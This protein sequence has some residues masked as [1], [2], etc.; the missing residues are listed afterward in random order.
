MLIYFANEDTVV[1]QSE[2]IFMPS[3][4]QPEKLALKFLAAIQFKL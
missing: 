4:F 3:F 2:Y 1:C